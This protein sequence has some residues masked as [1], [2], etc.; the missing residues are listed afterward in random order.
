MALFP[1]GFQA[2]GGGTSV[3]A[4]NYLGTWDASTNNPT[5]TSG[6]GTAGD[7]YIVSVAGNTNIDGISDWAVGDWIIFSSTGVWQKLDNSDL[8]GYNLIQEEGVAL[9]KESIIDFQ[10]AGVTATAGAGKTIV[11]IPGGI[12][13][14]YETVQEEGTSLPQQ[15]T[16]DFQGAGVTATDD[17]LN[18]KTIVTIPAGGLTYWTEA[19]NNT[20]PNVTTNVSSLTP[21]VPTADGD[22][23]ILPKGNGSLLTSIPDNTGTG[24]NKRG[25]S[26]VD[27]QAKRFFSTEVASGNFSVIGGGYANTSSASYS[28]VS[29]GSNNTASS[30]QSTISGGIGHTASG[31]GATVG[32]GGGNTASCIYSTVGGGKSNTASCI[33]STVGGGNQNTAS[34]CSS[35]IAG[36]CGNTASNLYS[37][38]GGG[39]QNTASGFYSTISGGCLNTASGLGSFVAGGISNTSSG[40]YSTISGGRLNT[41]S[42]N[43]TTISGGKCNTASNTYAT[44]IGGFG[45]CASGSYSVAS[46]LYSSTQGIYGRVSH[47]S[48]SFSSVRGEAQ[49]STFVLRASTTSATPTNLT[50]NGLAISTT[51]QV[52]LANQS[53]YRYK[54]TIVGKRPGSTDT[55]SW[56]IDGFIVRGA[57]AGTTNLIISN[58]NVVDNTPGWNTPTL[59]AD[60]TNGGL[61]VTANG[62]VVPFLVLHWVAVIETTEVI[63]A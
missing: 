2:G 22:A 58:V 49:K 1:F 11:T 43:Y 34:G 37:V 5:I 10:G 26:A 8:E 60:T 61:T 55:A 48:G 54:G 52:I 40:Y 18:N 38:I 59:S 57:G 42:C 41:A 24:G 47:S 56:D 35:V 13:Q 51:N 46:G 29:G 31:C 23:V 19:L 6:V 25:Q 14:A 17:P 7:Y 15:S 62:F 20:A 9:P 4:L 39:G 12:T 32:G 27:L 3:S 50:S 63:Y 28:T 53:S 44:V 21:N 45:S 30:Y 36:G 16:L 33:Y